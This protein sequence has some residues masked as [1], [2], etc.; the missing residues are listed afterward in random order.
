MWRRARLADYGTVTTYC[1]AHEPDTVG[2]SDR[3]F[4]GIDRD[5]GQWWQHLYL[6]GS[7][8]VEGM[9][10]AN[11]FGLFLPSFPRLDIARNA[12]RT[13]IDLPLPY[14]LVGRDQD[15]LCFLRTWQEPK[16]HWHYHSLAIE[17]PLAAPIPIEGG[18]GGNLALNLTRFSPISQGGL[19]I[20]PAQAADLDRLLPL[21]CE[22]QQEEVLASGM[23]LNVDA[24]RASLG[25]SIIHGRTLVAELGTEL[26]AK[27]CINALGFSYAQIGGVFTRKH[28][29]NH[30]IA[31]ALMKFMVQAILEEGMGLTLFVKRDNMPALRVYEKLGFHPRGAYSIVY[32]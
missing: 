27:A 7:E 10:Y 6:F 11:Q 15:T 9:L 8:P 5:L 20:R 28:W 12:A 26:A 30:G 3:L 21:E 1:R 22:Y 14:A 25:R 29:R 2:L 13:R 19:T 32:Y 23:M 18:K 31:S 17:A 24:L 16:L 4:T